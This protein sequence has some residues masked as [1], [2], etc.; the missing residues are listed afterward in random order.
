MSHDE[1]S[2]SVVVNSGH[3]C[4]LHVFALNKQTNKQTPPIAVS[5]ASKISSIL[6]V[7]FSVVFISKF[8]AG[9]FPIL[10]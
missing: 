7:I 5:P 10:R 3:A 1:Y 8:F 6:S 4:F 2:L 9:Q